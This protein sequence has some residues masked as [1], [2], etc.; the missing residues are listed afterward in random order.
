MYL[1]GQALF[2]RELVCDLGAQSVRSVALYARYDAK[3]AELC[4]RHGIEVVVDEI[5]TIGD[6]EVQE[7]SG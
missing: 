1:M 3:M 4:A 2:S 7:E 6:V 5:G